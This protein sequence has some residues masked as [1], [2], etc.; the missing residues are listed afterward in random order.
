MQ[1]SPEGLG[2]ANMLLQ[3]A[4]TA[5]E[6]GDEKLCVEILNKVKV[7]FEKSMSEIIQ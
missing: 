3:M 7:V 5:R 6:C 1:I 4:K 2:L